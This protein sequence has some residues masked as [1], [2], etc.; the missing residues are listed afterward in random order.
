MSNTTSTATNTTKK[1]RLDQVFALWKRKSK[2]GKTTYFTG[3]LGDQNITAFYVTNKK[4]L[5]EPDMRVYTRD[6]NGDRSKEPVVSLWCNATKNGKKILS[7]K[8]DGKR[9]VGFINANA[10]EKQ[11]Y[12]SVYWSD[13]SNAPQKDEKPEPKKEEKKPAMEQKT[14]DDD[15]ELPF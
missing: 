15:L 7:G 1:S 13:E 10:T 9:V 11:P 8:L 3:K 14:I 4:N 5:K 6:E 12:I 2:D